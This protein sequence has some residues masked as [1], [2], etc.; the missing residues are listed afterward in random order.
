[1]LNINK[2]DIVRIKERKDIVGIAGSAYQMKELWG[3]LGR[4]TEII[5]DAFVAPTNFRIEWCDDNNWLDRKISFL[6]SHFEVIKSRK[7]TDSEKKLLDELIKLI[8]RP[9]KYPHIKTSNF[10]HIESDG[11][12]KVKSFTIDFSWFEE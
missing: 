1:M 8:D 4:I 12:I 3:Q 7:E 10:D 5:Q 2:W 11:K 6:A 9:D